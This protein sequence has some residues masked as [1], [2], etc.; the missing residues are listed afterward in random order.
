MYEFVGIWERVL[1]LEDEV[2]YPC[3]LIAYVLRLGVLK[4]KSS[5]GR[6]RSGYVV[7][8]SAHA[9]ASDGPIFT[10]VPT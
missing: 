8:R 9:A 10:A 3:K 2:N 7:A 5:A 6:E 1:R 4:P